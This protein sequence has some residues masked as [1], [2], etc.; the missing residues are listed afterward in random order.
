M[1]NE[2]KMKKY[3]II[4]LLCTIPIIVLKAQYN[5]TVQTTFPVL[6][7]RDKHLEEQLDSILF[8]AYPCTSYGDKFNEYIYL[9]TVEEK[10]PECY[11]ID[12]IFSRPSVIEENVNTGIYKLED[13]GTFII[14]EKSKT[15]LFIKTCKEEK[16][17]Y[18]KFLVTYGKGDYELE[19]IVRPEQFCLTT[20]SYDKNHLEVLDV[21][22]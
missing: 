17:I 12:I 20:L 1:K 2:I 9:T 11:I 15:P 4:S 16:L 19:E 6:E 10:A 8:I 3:I 22:E 14:R 7:L 5:L 13:K 18:R 21:G